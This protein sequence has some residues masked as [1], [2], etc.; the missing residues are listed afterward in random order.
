MEKIKFEKHQKKWERMAKLWNEFSKPGR[1]SKGDIKNYDKLLK[2]SLDGKFSPR[3]IVLGATP[4]IR[5]LLYKYSKTKGAEIICVDMTK[6]MYMAMSKFVKNKNSKERFIHVNWIKISKKLKLAKADIVIGDFVIGN[7]GGNEVKFL[8]EISKVLKS[9]GSFITRA[10]IID[11]IKN[12]F[13]YYREFRRNCEQVRKG[14]ISIKEASSYFFNNLIYYGWYLNKKSMTSMSFIEDKD[15]EELEN[16]IKTS[17]NK[18]ESKVLTQLRQSWY[19]MKDK[20]WTVYKKSKLE[21][22]MKK[23]FMVKN[24][25]YSK[26]YEIVK[27]SPI[28]RLV[29]K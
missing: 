16:K 26:D 14:K 8:N 27:Q 15:L 20:Y 25:L 24:I 1:P 23:Y 4:E 17:G 5:N 7:I 19:L 28:Y 2:I 18:I 10:Q 12:K 13:N 11:G 21:K 22:M 9:G 3:I 6:D 29:K